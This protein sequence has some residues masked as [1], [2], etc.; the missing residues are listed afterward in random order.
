MTDEQLA[1]E[2]GAGRPLPYITWE[3][4]QQMPE[5]GRRHEAIGGELYGTPLPSVRHQRVGLKLSIALIELLGDAGEVFHAVGVVF[6]ETGEGVQPDLLCVSRERRAILVEPWIR[7]A[8][9]LVVEIT[10]PVTEDLDS[11][12]AYCAPWGGSSRRGRLR[13]SHIAWN[14][15]SD[16]T[17]A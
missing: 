12:A 14:R 15:G 2:S 3:D 1:E 11:P 5:D 4:A 8:P 6:P 13:R 10:S 17:G 9:D 16:S 7:G